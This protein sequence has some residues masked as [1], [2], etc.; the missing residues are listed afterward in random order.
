VLN[1]ER[2]EILAS[3]G[4]A[5]SCGLTSRPR[6]NIPDVATTGID[7]KS[8][9]GSCSMLQAALSSRRWCV[10]D[11]AHVH[12]RSLSSRSVLSC[13]HTE[14][15]CKEGEEP[16]YTHDLAAKPFCLV[17][18]LPFECVEVFLDRHPP[19]FLTRKSGLMPFPFRQTP[20]IHKARRSAGATKV[21]F[22]LRGWVKSDLMCLDHLALLFES[23]CDRSV[24]QTTGRKSSRRSSS[25]LAPSLAQD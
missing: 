25:N 17:L 5:A 21:G 18:H 12:S 14:H 10:P 9:N 23:P 11:W 8:R 7:P 19:M 1:S 22:L 13:L 2:L 24:S 6:A 15:L 16:I 4:I 3:T 20:G